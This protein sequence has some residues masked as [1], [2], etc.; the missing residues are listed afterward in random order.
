MNFKSKL[1]KRKEQIRRVKFIVALIKLIKYVFFVSTNTLYL[2]IYSC[3]GRLFH[4]E[5]NIKKIN[6]R[7]LKKNKN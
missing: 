7:L 1:F 6:V 5:T 4:E 2:S 3:D